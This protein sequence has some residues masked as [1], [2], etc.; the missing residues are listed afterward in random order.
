MPGRH[1]GFLS[2]TTDP[3]IDQS[4][5]TSVFD[6][7][8]H[9]GPV[10]LCEFGVIYCIYLDRA[11]NYNVDPFVCHGFHFTHRV[12]DLVQVIEKLRL[13]SLGF[14]YRVCIVKDLVMLAS[15]ESVVKL[16][17][18]HISGFLVFSDIPTSSRNTAGTCDSAYN[19]HDTR[20]KQT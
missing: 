10:A 2:T 13:D 19:Y 4:D 8:N 11:S 1:V 12:V 6:K 16:G 18:R 17:N 20:E 3:I 5:C 15:V 7:S 14:H 9:L